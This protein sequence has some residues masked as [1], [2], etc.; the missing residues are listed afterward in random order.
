MIT[1]NIGISA[2]QQQFFSQTRISPATFL[3]PTERRTLSLRV[4]ARTEPITH[5]ARDYNVSRKF[6]YQQSAKAR[7]ALDDTFQ[8]SPK[9]KN[10]IFH[11]PITK[12]W[13]RQFVLS[14]VLIGHSSFRAVI[15]I[16]DAVFDYRDISIGTIHNIVNDAVQKAKLINQKQP[17]SAIS[18]GAH[19]EIY[20]AGKPVLVGMDVD[21]TYCYLLAAE[22][23]C[24]ETTW[25]VH[26][27]D[28]SEEGLCLDYT[29]AD[30]GKGLRAGQKAAWGEEIPCHGDVFHAESELNKLASFL[31]RRAASC[32]GF[33]Q[34][35]E[36][37]MEKLKRSSDARNLS[38]KLALARQAETKAVCLAKDVRILVDWMHNDILSLCGPELSKRR[39]LYD[40]VV[41]EL[42]KRKLLCPHRIGPVCRMLKNHRDNLLAF[43]GVL[44]D[45]L[46][47]IAARFN[48]PVFLIHAVCELKG[49]DNND[50]VYWQRRGL[51]QN[52]LKDKFNPVEIA[53]RQAV[54]STPRASSI[55]ENPNSRL[56]NYFLLRRHIGNDYLDLLRFFLNHR[57]FER[58]ERTER[59]G[60]SPAELLTGNPHSHW[61]Q[62][63]GFDRFSRN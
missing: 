16:L 32:S 47:E 22:D 55:V 29:M 34:K 53:V 21:S 28:L 27:L 45:K 41:E 6:L 48:V 54:S 19:D 20:Q 1:N 63:L 26:L 57:R 13:I 4:L 49:L 2:C 33:R 44:D 15:E 25:G 60:K 58:S 12:D 56:R 36:C 9:D 51:L 14:Q 43:A 38:R 42:T 30:G 40:F 24:D 10:V 46:A 39:E 11:L 7:K 18:V 50:A 35:M 61:L 23:H 17:L 31:E 3:G 37:K 8:S 52:K 5:L 59:I 62:L